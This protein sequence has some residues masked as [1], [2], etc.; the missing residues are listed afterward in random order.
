MA[1]KG[2]E[3]LRALYGW[4]LHHYAW[5]LS[6]GK[7][8]DWEKG[9]GDAVNFDPV[10]WYELL[11]EG[12]DMESLIEEHWQIMGEF[13][14]DHHVKLVVDEWGPW[15]RPGSELT[16]GDQ[17]EQLPTLRDAVFS[18]M[19]LDTFNRHPEKVAV[20]CC[21]QLINCLNSL[22]LAHEDKF[23]V[24]PVGHVFALY[25]AHQNGQSLRS[26]FSAPSVH[27]DRDGKPAS[28]WGLRG[29][30]S[31]HDRQ[32]VNNRGQHRRERCCGNA[33]RGAWRAYQLRRSDC[34]DGFGHSC[35]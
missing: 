14:P 20:A 24:T 31:L 7:T 27:Y 2:K 34:A 5:N 3:Q 10:D 19:T 22:Y 17:L 1:R 23:C 26:E 9:K 29:S 8:Q 11:H 13:D 6:R 21:A 4:A 28:F 12:D 16:P 30:A 32:L 35:A 18:G 33:D 25:A 15:Y